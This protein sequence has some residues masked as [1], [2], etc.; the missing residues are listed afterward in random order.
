[1]G[2]GEELVAS[3]V[4]FPWL[5]PGQ[6][7]SSCALGEVGEVDWEQSSG[8]VAAS[9]SP[10]VPSPLRPILHGYSEDLL[11]PPCSEVIRL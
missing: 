6:A 5:G 11:A 8:Q 9:N 10:T 4:T 2:I 7:L 3:L 1:M